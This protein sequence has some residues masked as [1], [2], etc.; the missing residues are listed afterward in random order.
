MMRSI[1]TKYYSMRAGIF[2]LGMKFSATAGTML[3][4]TAGNYLAGKISWRNIAA[5]KQHNHDG[6]N[7]LEDCFERKR[8]CSVPESERFKFK[9][10]VRNWLAG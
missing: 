2:A 1:G 6:E 9:R 10:E 7:S 3:R 8:P 5:L 4:R